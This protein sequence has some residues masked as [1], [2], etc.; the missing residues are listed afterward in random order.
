M[1]V[2]KR[3]VEVVGE[4]GGEREVGMEGG[5]GMRGGEEKRGGM[6]YGGLECSIRVCPVL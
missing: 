3:E 5:S 6:A 1:S 2:W 4:G